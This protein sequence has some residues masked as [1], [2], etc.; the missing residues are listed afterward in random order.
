M[1]N[2]IK[3]LEIQTNTFDSPPGSAIHFQGF[4]KL[5]MLI[6]TPPLSLLCDCVWLPHL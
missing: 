3:E 1:H 4:Q 5:E 2:E 6:F